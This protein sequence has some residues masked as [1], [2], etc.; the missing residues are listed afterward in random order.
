MYYLIKNIKL[1]FLNIFISSIFI[2]FFIYFTY[3]AIYGNNGLKNNIELNFRFIELSKELELLE[4]KAIE[5]L[6]GKTITNVDLRKGWEYKKTL[7]WNPNIMAS[8]GSSG[9]WQDIKQWHRERKNNIENNKTN[10]DNLELNTSKE[11]DLFAYDEK[12]FPDL[13]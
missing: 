1:I 5:L 12:G 8:D 7:R 9:G 2:I 10:V 4:H 13:S 3:A 6:R 11:T